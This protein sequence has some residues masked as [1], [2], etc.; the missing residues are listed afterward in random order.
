MF[1]M[2]SSGSKEISS[3]PAGE[4]AEAAQCSHRTGPT[5]TLIYSPLKMPQTPITFPPP[6]RA[7]KQGTGQR[8]A[9]QTAAFSSSA[10]TP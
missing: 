10:L 3:S 6:V 8:Q 7:V 5:N 1:V 4:R 2:M 9:A